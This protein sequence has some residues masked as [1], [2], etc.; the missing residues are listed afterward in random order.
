MPWSLCEN[1]IWPA[2][3]LERGIEVHTFTIHVLAEE[4][5]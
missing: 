1:R 3:S 2:G 4:F 5:K